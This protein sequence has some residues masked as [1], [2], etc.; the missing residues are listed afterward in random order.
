MAR[1][2]RV[3]TRTGDSGDTSLFSADRVRKT[4]PRIEALGDLDEAQAALGV[5][6]ATIRGPQR[7]TVLD[8]QRGLYVAMSEIATPS[9]SLGRL[10][11][12]ID[13]DAVHLLDGLIE[14]LR[15]RANVEGRF[16]IPGEDPA[17]AQRSQGGGSHLSGST[18]TFTGVSAAC[19]ATDWIW[20]MSIGP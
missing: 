4:D 3:T 16:V 11:A 7:E 10:P 9:A 18:V 20:P 17:L 19:S 12:R 6:R 14:S 2:A 15:E 5:A 13:A 8:L 1:R